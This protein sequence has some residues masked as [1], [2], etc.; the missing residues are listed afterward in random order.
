[1]HDPSFSL[2]PDTRRDVAELTA[3]CPMCGSMTMLAI[4]IAWRQGVV[5]CCECQTAMHL[6]PA[7]LQRLLAQARGASE[8]ME[9]PLSTQKD[10][11]R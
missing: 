5:Y 9:R 6:T 7:V 3:G 10:E 8:M 2:L 1:V 11:L 4:Q